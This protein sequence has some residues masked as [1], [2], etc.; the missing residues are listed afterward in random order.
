MDL[1]V[2]DVVFVCQAMEDVF[3]VMLGV[4]WRECGGGGG[5]GGG[6]HG[7]GQFSRG[8]FVSICPCFDDSNFSSAQ[9]AKIA[10]QC[11]QW[12]SLSFSTGAFVCQERLPYSAL[13]E[14]LRWKVFAAESRS[15]DEVGDMIQ[16]CCGLVVWETG[17]CWIHGGLRDSF[18]KCVDFFDGVV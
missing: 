6:I 10:N 12:H 2:F 9:F 18:R 17:E 8:A 13:F 7:I 4:T 3:R 15:G 11:G 5:G 14:E 1:G 16:V